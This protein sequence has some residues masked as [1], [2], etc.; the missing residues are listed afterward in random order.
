MAA[1]ALSLAGD[2][3]SGI[4]CTVDAILKF[5][6]FFLEKRDIIRGG[7]YVDLRK[8][9]EFLAKIVERVSGA[10]VDFR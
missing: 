3:S 10:R 7:L 9:E 5:Q 2:E 1:T 8:Y 4:C 6:L